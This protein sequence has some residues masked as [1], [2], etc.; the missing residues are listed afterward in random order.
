ML[1]FV[2]NPFPVIQT[3]R[4]VLRKISHSDTE[5]LFAMRSDP[6]TM[7]FIPRPVA[8]HHDDVTELIQRILSELNENRSI[9]WAITLKEDNILIGTIGYVRMS[10]ENHRGEVGYMLSQH[11]YG[12]GIM[13]EALTAVIDYGFNKLNLHSIEGVVSPENMASSNVLKKCG[14]IREAYYKEKEYVNGKFE[15][16]EVYSL[17]KS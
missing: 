10:P 14:F 4:L 3:E 2:F 11:H 15:D 1:S 13:N 16:I 6:S 17:I 12:K 7:R 5:S 8:R 9:N